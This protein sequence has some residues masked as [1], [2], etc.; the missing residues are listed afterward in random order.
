MGLFSSFTDAVSSAFSGAANAVGDAVES[1]TNTVGDA[2]DSVADTAGDALEGVT[3]AYGSIKD[4]YD[5][6]IDG[7]G[8]L[9]TSD[10]FGAAVAGGATGFASGGWWGAAPGAASAYVSKD[11]Q[12]SAEENAKE[13]ERQATLINRKTTDAYLADQEATD[14]LTAQLSNSATS[15]NVSGGFASSYPTANAG[16]SLDREKLLGASIVLGALKKE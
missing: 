10:Q 12:M 6:A 9:L 13:A 4:G 15:D 16:F 8:D 5:G 2:A 7:V 11:A 14:A 3:D 1:V